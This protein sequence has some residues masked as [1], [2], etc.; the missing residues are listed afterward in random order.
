MSDIKAKA[1]VVV[2]LGRIRSR[3]IQQR[4]QWVQR[5]AARPEARHII[6][7]LDRDLIINADLLRTAKEALAQAKKDKGDHPVQNPAGTPESL[8][9]DSSQPGAKPPRVAARPP[10]ARPGERQANGRRKVT[11]RPDQ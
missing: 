5:Q 3:L 7:E 6:A 4:A 10:N 2:K 9:G 11:H 8:T 1:K